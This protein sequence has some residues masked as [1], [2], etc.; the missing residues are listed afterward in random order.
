M[1][2]ERAYKN[3]RECY[4]IGRNKENRQN[5][6]SYT[7]TELKLR[8]YHFNEAIKSVEE[9]RNR[10][11]KIFKELGKNNPSDSFLDDLV[12]YIEGKPTK[13]DIRNHLILLDTRAQNILKICAKCDYNEPRIANSIERFNMLELGRKNIF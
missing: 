13:E 7:N 9:Q 11:F 8:A 12:N 3:C 5:K 2:F 4:E 1:Y 10:Y 6:S